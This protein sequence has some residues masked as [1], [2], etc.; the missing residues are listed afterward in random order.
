[1]EKEE[2]SASAESE[3]IKISGFNVPILTKTLRD[4]LIPKKEGVCLE[5]CAVGEPAPL[6]VWLKNGEEIIPSPEYDNISISNEGYASKLVIHRMGENDE[7]YYT[8]QI[9]NGK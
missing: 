7:G 5:I 9:S 4:A 3:I 8:C 2:I 1:M 6:F